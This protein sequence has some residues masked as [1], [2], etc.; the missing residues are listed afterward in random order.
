[1]ALM[2]NY[3]SG[4]SFFYY[5]LH[6][7][8]EEVFGSAKQPTDFPPNVNNDSHFHD[9]VNLS[10]PQITIHVAQPNIVRNVRM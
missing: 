1:M 7:K 2:A 6:L 3:M 5:V 4:S 8:G 9:Y 10:R